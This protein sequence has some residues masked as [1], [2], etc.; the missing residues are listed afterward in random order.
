MVD[1]L[2]KMGMGTYICAILEKSVGGGKGIGKRAFIARYRGNLVPVKIGD[3]AKPV[4][5]VSVGRIKD[6][7]LP[8]QIS[9]FV[10][11]V[12]RIKKEIKDGIPESIEDSGSFVPEFSG[13]RRSYS[14]DATVASEVDHG[15]VVGALADAITQAGYTPR[16]DRPRDMYVTDDRHNRMSVLFEVKTKTET[17]DIYQAIGQ[18]MFN[19]RAREAREDRVKLVLVIPGDLKEDTIRRF[20]LLDIKTLRYQWR[21]GKP[22]FRHSEVKK[23]LP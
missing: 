22:V 1:Y 6:R 14:L 23:L 12:S 9:H 8:I 4:D 15:I 16:N 7:R 13:S 17:T 10:H 19:G 3:R 2:R 20:D 5:V 18:L 11:E 21:K